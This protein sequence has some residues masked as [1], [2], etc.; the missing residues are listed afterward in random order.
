MPMLACGVPRTNLCFFALILRARRTY[1]DVSGSWM[2]AFP[3]N[4]E[5]IVGGL[6]KSY[7]EYDDMPPPSQEPN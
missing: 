7:S 5:L 2:R 1:K 4:R 3:C 6:V